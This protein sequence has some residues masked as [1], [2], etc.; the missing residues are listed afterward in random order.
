[1]RAR[2]NWKLFTPV[3]VAGLVG[4]SA[5]GVAIADAVSQ[6]P[7]TRILNS[8]A[9]QPRLTSRTMLDRGGVRHL[10]TGVGHISSRDSVATTTTLG[11][12]T[13]LAPP[14]PGATSAVS[15]S[16]AWNAFVAY[17]NVPNV[18]VQSTTPAPTIDLGQITKSNAPGGAVANTLVWV[19]EYRDIELLNATAAVEDKNLTGSIG[20]L[21]VFVSAQ[22]GSVLYTTANS[23]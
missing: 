7:A 14:A 2:M 10:S 12:G 1:M 15:Q 8:A 17:G 6:S 11:D 5:G 23:N 20:T 16:Q 3:A 13:V 21:D 4:L 22:T 19:I 18:Y 9:T